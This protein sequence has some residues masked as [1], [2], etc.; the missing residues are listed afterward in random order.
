[1][2]HVGVT[3]RLD[4]TIRGQQNR[5]S[6]TQTLLTADSIWDILLKSG[7]ATLE[8]VEV[9]AGTVAIDLPLMGAEAAVAVGYFLILLLLG[10]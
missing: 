2:L 9:E 8:I 5:K 1:M 7:A 6:E 3:T 10:H 4:G